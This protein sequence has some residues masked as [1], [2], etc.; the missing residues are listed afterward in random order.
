MA[1][2]S[3]TFAPSS[4][5]RA[6]SPSSPPFPRVT[7]TQRPS[8]LGSSS[9]TVSAPTARVPSR[10]RR[11]SPPAPRERSSSA[12]ATPMRAASATGPDRSPRMI[13]VPSRFA[14]S[15]RSRTSPPFT[16][17]CPA[18]GTW[19]P[20][21]SVRRNPRSASIWM[22]VVRSSSGAR[23]RNVSGSSLRASMA[24]APCAT[25]GSISSVEKTWTTL[26]ASP[27]R[28][29]PAW[30]STTASKPS[31]IFRSRVATLPRMVSIFRL[32]RSACSWA[33]RRR[34]AVPTFA[35]R[36]RS[37]RRLPWETSASRGSSRTGTAAM[38]SPSGSTAGRS[39]IEWTAIWASPRRSASS[40]SFTKSPLPPTSA[41]GTSRIR[42]PRVMSSSSWTSRPGSS[43][44]SREE[45]WWACHLA[46]A[47]RRVAIR[48]V[49]G[50]TPAGRQR[51][52]RSPDG[53]A[54]AGSVR[55]RRRRARRPRR[56]GRCRPR[57]RL[58]SAGR[59]GPWRSLFTIAWAMA[60][61]LFRPLSSSLPPRWESVR[62]A[63]AR[64]ICSARRR[65]SASTGSAARV[66]RSCAKAITSDS[67][68]ASARMASSARA[69][70]VWTTTFCRSSMS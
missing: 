19:Q 20:P 31:S 50:G 30:A 5:R 63:S 33:E 29:S 12:S 42:S 1:G 16:S 66:S 23:R 3:S 43:P 45:T 15:P 53:G 40:I 49:I 36:G 67:T 38:T 61:T 68:M 55:P 46:R 37:S 24:S 65:S 44:T 6:D 2:T 69:A 4:R 39:F 10:W 27:S 57:R 22:R 32:G 18:M 17:A 70:W 25:A 62:S 9:L 35:P 48:T 13:T 14:T 21:C 8:S 41:S 28:F 26:S 34:L 54:V 7:A 59:S 51:R 47:L 60:S 58:P 11:G 52:S 56:G 64:A